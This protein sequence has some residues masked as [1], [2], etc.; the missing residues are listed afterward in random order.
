[1]NKLEHFGWCISGPFWDLRWNT[2][3]EN[4][5]GEV[6]RLVSMRCA[7]TCLRCPG[8]GALKV[9]VTQLKSEAEM[10]AVIEEKYIWGGKGRSVRGKKTTEGDLTPW[11]MWEQVRLL[12]MKLASLVNLPWCD[13]YHCWAVEVLQIHLV[14]ARI[15]H[16]F[17]IYNLA[18]F[19]Y[20]FCMNGVG[21]WLLEGSVM[22]ILKLV[23]Q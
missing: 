12:D 5:Q 18:K 19:T 8:T 1:M 9:Q 16:V 14:T 23:Q 2:R 4:C 11:R 22:T 10:A 13:F 6:P 20:C 7:G 3:P 15:I 21:W 17:I